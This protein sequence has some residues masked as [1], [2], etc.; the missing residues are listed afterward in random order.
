MEKPV[1]KKFLGKEV[2][3]YKLIYDML[4]A[5]KDA[6]K[7]QDT[8]RYIFLVKHLDSTFPYKDDKYKEE[9]K[10]AEAFLSEEMDN[11]LDRFG[12]PIEGANE[13]SQFKFANIMYHELVE[14]IKRRKVFPQ[15]AETE[16]F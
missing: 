9:I 8:Q 13:S 11:M 16:E 5:I 1:E 3:Y 4:S 15:E 10:K 6:V 7:V 14:L 12:K 2:E